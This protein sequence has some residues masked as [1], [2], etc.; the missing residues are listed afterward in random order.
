MVYDYPIAS[1]HAQ[2]A[3]EIL[4]ILP[5]QTYLKGAVLAFIDIFHRENR[6]SYDQDVKE[7]KRIVGGAILLEDLDKG[8]L[9]FL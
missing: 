4:P 9:Y 1:I 3:A 5:K 7:L 8:M 6:R 2:V